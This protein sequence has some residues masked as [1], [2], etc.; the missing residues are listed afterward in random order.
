MRVMITILLA[1]IQVYGCIDI[2]FHF[3]GML[4]I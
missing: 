3:F 4:G 1:H 2:N